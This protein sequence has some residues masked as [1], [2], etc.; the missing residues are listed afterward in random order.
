L[1]Q[2]SPLPQELSQDAG[3]AEKKNFFLNSHTGEFPLW[4]SS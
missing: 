3:V 2:M 4:L 1:E